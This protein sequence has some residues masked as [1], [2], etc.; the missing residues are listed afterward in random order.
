MTWLLGIL[1]ALAAAL[2]VGLVFRLLNYISRHSIAIYV[3]RSEIVVAS[4]EKR[5]SHRVFLQ[6]LEA[7]PLTGNLA[8]QISVSDFIIDKPV[9][10]FAGPAELIDASGS[11]QDKVRTFRFSE[12]PAF[13]TWM[14]EVQTTGVAA[15]TVNVLDF[16][17][18]RPSNDKAHKQ[19]LGTVSVDHL[20]LYPEKPQK[21]EGAEDKPR[22]K[23]LYGTVALVVTGYWLILWVFGTECRSGVSTASL[24]A[25]IMQCGSFNLLSWLNV[26]A[27]IVLMLGV[28]L[29][30]R[31]ALRSAPPIAQGYLF[32]TK[33][34]SSS[35][36]GP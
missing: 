27:S 25:S 28:S 11:G 32:Q 5:F 15:F 2:W 21:L 19:E 23:T 12:L 30:F 34:R 6:N 3:T 16:D 1:Q 9:K 13:D 17:A 4:H 18:I 20:V 7:T 33:I 31:S 8:I 35:A 22:L 26:G 36:I 29:S 10:I 24:Q 14:L